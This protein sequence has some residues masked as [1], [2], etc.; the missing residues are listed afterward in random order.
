MIT[1]ELV[2]LMLFLFAAGGLAI[3]LLLVWAAYYQKIH[4]TK[5][6]RLMIYLTIGFTLSLFMT[7]ASLVMTSQNEFC[8]NCHEMQPYTKAF[9][10]SV[11]SQMSCLA[12]H[13]GQGVVEFLVHKVKS[14]KE[15]Y[16]H[17]TNS[18]HKPINGSGEL[19]KEMDE[20]L[21]E[22]CHNL[23]QRKVTARKDLI[24]NHKKHKKKGIACPVCHN[25]VAHPDVTLYDGESENKS[26]P[27]S[28]KIVAGFEKKQHYPNRMKMRY[29]MRCHTG[30]KDDNKGP[31]EC[32]A[33]HPPK[34]IKPPKNHQV[35]G[36][37][38]STST[39]NGKAEEADY[40]GGG[41]QKALHSQMASFDNEYCQACHD[42]TKF[43]IDCHK[44]EMPHPKTKWKKDHAKIG[45]ESPDKCWTCH[46][47][48]N[49]CDSCH[50]D[51]DPVKGPW[52]SETKGKS[53]HPTIVRDRGAEFCFGCHAPTYCAHCHV[54]GKPD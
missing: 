41:G 25:R 1:W 8:A 5:K 44:V 36:F 22:R 37:L 10:K 3:V 17:L 52:V 21:C 7:F 12:C 18:Y 53:Y 23:A 48:Q 54:T 35:T 20:S 45:Q 30:E 15:P 29:C 28:L 39:N 47:K 34:Y 50:H 9:E 19:S 33:C 6:L 31:K 2:W 49:F 51:Y 14:V 32:E 13:G 46:G 16:L 43:C 40:E 24:I 42:D 26:L 4:Q 11:H 38:H 27:N